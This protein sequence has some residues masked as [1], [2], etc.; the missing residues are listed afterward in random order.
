MPDYLPFVLIALACPITMGA[1]MWFMMKGMRAGHADH[2]SDEGPVSKQR[3]D[4][5]GA[6][7]R[8]ATAPSERP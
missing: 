7:L 4:S 6:D 1:I 8:S 3:A 2:R 5:G